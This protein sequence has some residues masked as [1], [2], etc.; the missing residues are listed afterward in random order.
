M[1]DTQE[2]Y[3]YRAGQKVSLKKEPDQFVVRALPEHLE[4][5][6]ITDA[7]QMSSASSRVTVRAPDL[8]ATMSRARHLAPTHHAYR[9]AET[10]EEF[11]I[12]DRVFVTFHEALPADQVD[13]FAAQ[14]ALVQLEK[15]SE[16]DYLFQ[17]TDHTGMNPVKLVI[18]LME[19]EPLVELADHDLNYRVQTYQISLP[20][21][22]AYAQ[23]W[24]LHTR[25]NH[26]EFDPRS[27]S[28]CEEAWQLLDSFGS[29][30]V[31]VGVT[32]DGCKLDHPDFD[33]PGKFAGWGYFR[34]QR[35][36]KEHE[37][38]A[39]PEEMYK[40]G[41]NHGTSCAGVIGGEVD[42]VLTVGGGPG[43]RLL[44]LQWE[45]EGSSLFISDSKLMTALDYMADK[46][47]I[48]SNSW[49][50]VPTN[51]R[52]P[53]LRNRIAELAQTGG[54]RGRGIVFLWAAGNENCPIE[55][56]VP[57]NQPAVPF[58][59]GVQRRADG[60][61]VWVG[62]QTTRTFRN[63]LAD[64]PGVIH[65]A[66][67]AS[68]ARRSHYSNYGTGIT[69]CAPSSNVHTYRRMTVQGLGITTTTGSIEEV[70]AGFG[71]TSSATPLVAGVAGLVISANPA[72]TALEVI[73][74]LK[75]TAS[76][77]LD[78]AGYPKTP[79]A[80]FDP[81]TSWDV[82]P[83]APFD[84]GEF[85]D[86]GDPDG[87]WSP[88]FGHGRVDAPAAVAEAL[89]LR[90]E[91]PAQQLHYSA[92]PNISIPDNDTTG[93]QDVIQIPDAG[94]IEEIQVQVDIMHTWIGDLRIQLIAPDGT[95]VLLHNRAGGSGDNVQQTYD[96]SN[97]PALASFRE[98]SITG[99][100]RLHIQDLASRDVG[101][102]NSWSLDIGVSA[103]PLVA[104]EATSVQIPDHD[105]NGIV[106]SL[107]LPGGHTVQE[108]AVSVDITHTWIGD[109]QVTLTSPGGT[110]V[111]LHN[112]A[113]GSADN[114]VETW[115]S[116]DLPDLRDLR[117][118]DTGGSWQLRVADL[119]SRDIGKLNRWKI[120]VV[121]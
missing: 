51:I 115:R 86:T 94:Q 42:A 23:Q 89:R 92:T 85:I 96:L 93:I 114:L 33:S 7:E 107:D 56:T 52:I 106:R 99:A 69:L 32:D 13:A 103:E 71:G 110:P 116:Q 16:R 120:E 19:N 11:L 82:S 25:L 9:L 21:D 119:V 74:V 109:L 87:T 84:A 57:A 91:E 121:G 45:S 83:I 62:V 28:R 48:I 34:G 8:E 35:L 95:S 105:P 73:S 68:T 81:D 67:L 100:W 75:R 22:P 117:G 1:T 60:S 63:N 53:V 80:S 6:G 61:L 46:V 65:I 78:M 72:L 111:R 90:G 101:T 2:T 5:V 17:L 77:D 79:P 26:P 12:T 29:A 54:R 47:D 98:L 70:T 18:K 104:E 31:V 58:T 38:D 49:G 24:H 20:S 66:A 27:S 41:A 39:D 97:L 36:I 113:G 102:L 4:A 3:T 64:L 14:Y 37:I 112:R 55:H 59:N 10:D 15:Y 118:Q 50:R 88:W 44:P 40:S 43:C 76:K 108:I 30:D